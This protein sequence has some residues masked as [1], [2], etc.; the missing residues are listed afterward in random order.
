M[1]LS[2]SVWLLFLGVIKYAMNRKWI[3][4]TLLGHMD[5]VTKYRNRV[6]ELQYNIHL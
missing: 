4:E 3:Y 1:Q 2:V 5:G 6:T